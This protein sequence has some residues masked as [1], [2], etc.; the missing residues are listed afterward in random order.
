[1][2]IKT[3][4]AVTIVSAAMMIG[5]KAQASFLGTVTTTVT[6]AG[7]ENNGAQVEVGIGSNPDNCS[8]TAVYFVNSAELG[9]ALAIA[10]ASRLSGRNVRVDYTQP[11]GTGTTCIGTNIYLQ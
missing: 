5:Q 1:M 8:Y 7:S 9:R 4:T 3:I 10:L 2:S 11:G 6:N